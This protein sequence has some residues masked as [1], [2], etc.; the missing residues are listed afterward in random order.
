[1]IVAADNSRLVSPDGGRIVSLP[2]GRAVVVRPVRRRYGFRGLGQ[3]LQTTGG[4]IDTGVSDAASAA[5]AVA[6]LTG[7]LAPFVA[8]G[9]AVVKIIATFFQPNLEKIQAS[10]DAN[11]LGT[12]LDN[13]RNAYVNLPVEQRTTSVQQ[14]AIAVFNEGWNQYV[15]AVQPDLAKAP[16]S[17]SDRQA[18]A[19]AYHVAAPF[20]WAGP[21]NYVQ[22]GPNIPNLPKTPVAGTYCYNTFSGDLDPIQ[23]DPYVSPDPPNGSSAANEIS[24]S[25][26]VPTSNTAQAFANSPVA[27]IISA[28]PAWLWLVGGAALLWAVAQ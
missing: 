25:G 7:P 18:G 26:D 2:S 6:P 4:E 8:A 12:L 28:V 1:M 3:S 5:L 20:G 11:T 15:Q 14:A 13:N 23:N 19:C 9:A 16:D 27:S 24:E 22:A 17:I 21:N 10:N